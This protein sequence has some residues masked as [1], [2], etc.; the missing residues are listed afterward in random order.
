MKGRDGLSIGKKGRGE[1]WEGGRR[2]K[3]GWKGKVD[4]R[5][6]TGGGID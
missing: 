3:K 6:A 2:E 4:D 1:D 5:K